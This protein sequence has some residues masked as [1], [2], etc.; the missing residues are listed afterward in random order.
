[1]RILFSNWKGETPQSYFTLT[2]VEFAFSPVTSAALS[3][4]VTLTQTEA[5]ENFSFSEPAEA[6]AEAGAEAEAEAGAEAGEKAASPNPAV[7][8]RS[9]QGATM[10]TTPPKPDHKPHPKE[11]PKMDPKPDKME[12][13]R[14]QHTEGLSHDTPDTAKHQQQQC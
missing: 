6:G 7:Y 8:A 9:P 1:M 5:S 3:S 12:N 10:S 4:R 13:K 11:D 2:F 14:L